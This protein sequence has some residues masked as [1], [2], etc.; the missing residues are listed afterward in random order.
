MRPAVRTL[1]AKCA[2]TRARVSAI[3]T[4]LGAIQLAVSY[5]VQGWTSGVLVNTG[6]AT[7]LFVPLFYIQQTLE[8]RVRETTRSVEQLKLDVQNTKNELRQDVEDLRQKFAEREEALLSQQDEEMAQLDSSPSCQL[9]HR[10][11]LAAVEEHVISEQWGFRV[12]VVNERLSVF[13]RLLPVEE[14]EIEVHIEAADGTLFDAIVWTPDQTPSEFMTRVSSI[15]RASSIHPG[16]E[17]DPAFLFARLREDL[18]IA[19]KVKRKLTLVDTLDYAQ[20]YIAPQWIVYDWGI[21]SWKQGLSPYWIGA[22]ALEEQD[23]I[24]HMSEKTW[25]DQDSF[26]MALLTAVALKR[27]GRLVDL[28]GED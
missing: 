8:V 11:L 21:A 4:I 18:S 17:F 7:L 22:D 15:L 14:G 27:D 28:N 20:Q 9:V 12:H 3:V 16:S 24:H 2:A 19:R 5:H 10:V 6:T 26:R 1:L 13:A 25:V 23:W